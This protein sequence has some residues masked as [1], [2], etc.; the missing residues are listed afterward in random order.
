[1]TFRPPF[2]PVRAGSCNTAA[3]NFVIGTVDPDGFYNF[4]QH[5]PFICA[6]PPGGQEAYCKGTG[7]TFFA[8]G[9]DEDPIDDGKITSFTRGKAPQGYSA[10]PC[11]ISGV[12][13]AWTPPGTIPQNP[14]QNNAYNAAQ[15]SLDVGDFLVPAGDELY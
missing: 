15:A 6:T 13:S 9:D 3:C 1:M 2:V 7:D 4:K 8:F 14:C 12:N 10:N 11:V 5:S